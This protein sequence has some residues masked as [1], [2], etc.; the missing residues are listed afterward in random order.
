MKS[1][2]TSAAHPAFA[3]IFDFDG[4]IV[5]SETPEFEAHRQIFAEHGVTL[6]AEEWL[7]E[8]GSYEPNRNWFERLGRRLGRDLDHAALREEKRR[9][10]WQVVIMEPMPGIRRLLDALTTAT[11]PLALASSSELSWIGRA[12]Q[13][14]DVARCFRTI[15]TGNDVQRRKPDPE[16]YLLAARRLGIPPAR[17]VAIEDSEHGLRAAQAAGMKTVVIPNWLTEMQD[18]SGAHLRVRSAEELD[19]GRLARLVNNG[20]R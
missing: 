3:V 15:V 2:Q 13:M 12:T 16:P 11:V 20:S 1:G 17:C 9:R 7:E 14:L 4:L 19:V 10:F 18:L 8:V 6:T 5:D